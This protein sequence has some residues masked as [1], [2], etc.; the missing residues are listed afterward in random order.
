[1]EHINGIPD[2]LDVEAASASKTFGTE[3]NVLMVMK[4]IVYAAQQAF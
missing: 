1:M 2:L 3:L 4:Y